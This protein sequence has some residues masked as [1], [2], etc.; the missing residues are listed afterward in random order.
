M[1]QAQQ[2][3]RTWGRNAGGR[4][5]RTGDQQSWQRGEQC[6]RLCRVLKAFV[7]TL[8]FTQLNFVKMLPNLS[9][10]PKT[11]FPGFCLAQSSER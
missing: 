8:A 4:Y 11:G 7:S 6:S 5:L 10:E 3:Q 2:V 9:V 1:Y